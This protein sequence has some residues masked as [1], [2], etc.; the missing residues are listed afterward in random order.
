MHPAVAADAAP[1]PDP[2]LRRG[3]RRAGVVCALV[4]GAFVVADGALLPARGWL[5]LAVAALWFAV[6]IG[7][8]RCAVRA[9][10]SSQVSRRI[11]L[12]FLPL[13]LIAVTGPVLA[14]AGVG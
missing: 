8:V 11:A 5:L 3:A 9:G 4:A 1:G 7:R 10:A 12:H 14:V 13:L 2:R 6:G